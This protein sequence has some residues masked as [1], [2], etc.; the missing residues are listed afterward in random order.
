MD[1]FHKGEWTDVQVGSQ[2][3]PDP[4]SEPLYIESPNPNR[5]RVYKIT[6]KRGRVL[7]GMFDGAVATPAGEF[8]DIPRLQPG[9]KIQ[10]RPPIFANTRYELTWKV[11]PGAICS[12]EIDENW[13][14][15]LGFFMGDGSW[16]NDSLDVCCDAKDKDVVAAAEEVI[17][18]T[19]GNPHRQAVARVQGRMGAMRLRL[20]CKPA[21]TVLLRLGV[22]HRNDDGEG[23]YKRHIC[24]PKCI[25]GS[26]RRVVRQFLRGLFEAD[27][28]ASGHKVRFASSKVDFIRDVQL[29]LLGFSINSTIGKQ[30]K[31]SGQKYK[32][33]CYTL[34]LGVE[35]SKVFHDAIGFVG[36]RKQ[37]LRQNSPPSPTTPRGRLTIAGRWGRPPLPND[38]TDEVERIEE[39]DC[40]LTNDSDPYYSLN[41]QQ[42]QFAR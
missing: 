29:L 11:I 33:T 35:A 36:R 9:Q 22:L 10:L 21:R 24:V 14:L 39:D 7:R 2:A 38:L 4:V 12:V 5:S 23:M 6:T 18:K 15:F 3:T 17:R 8:I 16:H 30:V 13:A 20:G 25:F 37:N 1:Y 40:G 19:L 41:Q 26:P 28:S 27:G 42:F 34:D 32:Y 31:E